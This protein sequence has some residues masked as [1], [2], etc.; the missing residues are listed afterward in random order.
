MEN[1]VLQGSHGEFDIPSVH[2][3][4]TTGL[5]EI[6]GESY[7]EN[8]VAFY[9]RLINWLDQYIKEVARPIT[10]NFKL[11]YFNTS[12]SK[13]ILHIMLK[14]KEYQLTGGE[15][16]VNWYYHNE[17]IEME[18]DVEDLSMIAK[19]NVNMIHDEGMAAAD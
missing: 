17:D 11:S 15:V 3:D 2:F 9:D 6:S 10:F 1:L 8:T 19:L 16:T 5:C 18:E 12:S 13:R 14:L 4:A 7:L